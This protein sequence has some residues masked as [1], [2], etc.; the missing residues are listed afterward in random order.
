MMG[1]V[2]SFLRFAAM[3]YGRCVGL[4]R[5][6][7]KPKGDEWAEFLKRHGR[8][9]SIGEHC[10]ILPSTDI[11]DPEYVRLGNN[12]VLSSCALIG[13][14][15]VVAMLNHSYCLKLD[16]VGKI[17]IRDNVFIGYGAIIL[18]GV[19]IGPNAVVGAGAV[20]TRDVAEGDIVGGVP[21]RPIGRVDDL[22]T[23]LREQ[24]MALPWADLIER[25][26]G[27]WAYDP[28]MEPELVRMR[29]EYFYGGRS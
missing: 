22:I 29:V 13:H 19:T 27:D 25:R 24:T 11:G 10:F 14:D 1:F 17:D 18:R 3:R 9:Y 21:A 23:K 16:A 12:V 4:Y 2:K 26:K 6:F 15:A 8:L 20:V 7:C 5:R 28:E